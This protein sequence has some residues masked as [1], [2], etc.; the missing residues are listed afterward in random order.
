MEPFTK[1]ILC[2]LVYFLVSEY[3]FHPKYG[4]VYRIGYAWGRGISQAMRE[5]LT[6]KKEYK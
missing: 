5:S 3:I 2:M 1:Y 4:I 6:M